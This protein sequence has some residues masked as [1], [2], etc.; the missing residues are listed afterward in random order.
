M[1][2][3]L[4]GSPGIIVRDE[5]ARKE[6]KEDIGSIGIILYAEPSPPALLAEG[7]IS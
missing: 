4:S 5:A 7:D 6:L 2:T 3:V 1:W